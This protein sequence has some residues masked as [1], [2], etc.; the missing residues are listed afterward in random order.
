MIYLTTGLTS[1][2]KTLELT[3]TAIKLLRRN[4][5]WYDK[6]GKIRKLAPNF[7]ISESLISRVGPEFFHRW[8]DPEELPFLHECDVLWDEVAN[9]MD[10]NDWQNVPLELKVFLRQHAKRGI[11][12][13]GT[14]QRWGSVAISFRSLVDQLYVAHK[15][16]GSARPSAT[17]PEI[18]KPW[19]IVFLDE[20][21]QESFLEDKLISCG[22]MG[23]RFLFITKELCDFYDTK[24]E[25]PQAKFAPLKHIERFCTLENCPLHTIGKVTHV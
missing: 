19:G 11:D 15:I 22:V 10:S 18:K 3:R 7:P 2:G 21:K 17:K 4:K 6:T 16:I 9:G 12:I 14:T 8:Y 24:Y 1:Q 20:Q 25:V 5:K 13:Y 23:Y